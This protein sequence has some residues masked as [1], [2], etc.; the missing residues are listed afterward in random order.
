MNTT[1]ANGD[2][3]AVINVKREDNTHYIHD[4][5]ECKV[6]TS[7]ELGHYVELMGNENKYRCED[8]KRIFIDKDAPTVLIN[9]VP[10]VEKTLADEPEK[11]KHWWMLK[12]NE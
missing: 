12:Y 4:T 7:N 2:R 6:L 3:I 9:H 10:S 5:F 8:G 11:K 1:Y